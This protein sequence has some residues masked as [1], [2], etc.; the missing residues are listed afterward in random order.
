MG[1]KH[2]FFFFNRVESTEIILEMDPYK[3][4]RKHN[5]I[6]PSEMKAN[7]SLEYNLLT[8]TDETY[9]LVF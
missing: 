2:S 5:I 6:I 4:Y 1:S 7:V 3:V 9:N 8:I